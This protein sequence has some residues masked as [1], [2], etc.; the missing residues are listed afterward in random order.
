MALNAE[1][2]E[3]TRP[4]GSAAAAGRVQSIRAARETQRLA[5][6]AEK[7]AGV[8]HWRFDVLSGAVAGSEAVRRSF[9]LDPAEAVPSPRRLLALLAPEDRA[10][11][12]RSLM[13]AIRDATPFTL[14][15]RIVTPGGQVRQVACNGVA[16]RDGTGA[17]AALYG[18]FQDLTETRA[19]ERASEDRFRLLAE[20]TTDVIY[21]VDPRGVITYVTPACET[22][23][24][25]APE[26]MIGTKV[27]SYS[28]PDDVAPIRAVIADL[29]A[30]GPG[31]API[32]TLYRVRRKD[33]GHLWVEGR[34]KINFD[35]A[36]VQVS[37]QDV[38]RDVTAQKEA[39]AAIRRSEERFRMLAENASDILCVM[40]MT[41]AVT[42]VT[43]ACEKLLGYT[44]AEMIGVKVQNLMHPD[45]ARRILAQTAA[46]VAAGPGAEW[47][48]IEYRSWH[49]EGRWVWIEGKPK[50]IFDAK[51]RPT[52][53]QDV[54]RDIGVRKAAELE[55][56]RA[57]DAAEAATAA[58]SDFLANMS[59]EIR[60]PLTAIIGF[61][62]LLDK[63]EEL[64]EDSR[65]SVRRIV[66][67]GQ[68]LLTLV[69]DI[70]DFSKLE[71][72]Q[73]ALDPQPFEPAEF[74]RGVVDLVAAQAQ[75]KGLTVDLRLDPDLP[76]LVEADNA[77]LRQILLNLLTNALKFTETGGVTV[78]AGYR[79]A[80]GLL[81]ISVTD[82]GSG[83]PEAKRGRLFER[84]SQV[85]SSVS[86]RQGGVGLGLAIC[87]SLVE[88]MGGRIHVESAEGVGSTFNFTVAAPL[89]AVA[90]PRA[91]LAKVDPE[92]A[93]GRPGQVLVVDDVA[94]N[95]ELIR[96]LLE[97]IGQ[98]VEEASSGAEA[99]S[100]AIGRTYDLILM[101]IQMPGM[102]GMTATRAIR[103]TAPLN[104]ATPIVA[105]S[106]NVLADQVARCLA[107]GMDDH[108]AKPIQVADFVAKVSHWIGAERLVA[109]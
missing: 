18:A 23:L 17:V 7:L 65:R 52:A 32:V 51:G 85:D 80:D 21:Q 11:V 43:Q 74:V 82:T 86:R 104:A 57:R 62:A 93:A 46:Y 27:L 41:G 70:L 29:I 66:T 40:D 50:I 97:A 9:G 99:I 68:A 94:E 108:I 12:R 20:H 95:R 37:L 63:A 31:A 72:N 53:I 89:V 35:A 102:D 90:A 84:F 19:R 92:P 44:P 16:E 5:R 96:L 76:A 36:G 83:I 8:G 105:I 101:D 64:S 49:K 79:H 60:T 34:P 10:R 100:A 98:S 77:R 26:E 30:A 91:P 71:A 22:L 107:A 14:E 67:G 56:A 106:A 15:G 42:F 39:D 28:H 3:P 33:G 61:S 73:V 4:S 25:Y 6:M 87:K 13:R 38:I 24:G 81:S 47:I 78:S 54:V 75:A 69:N 1:S 103:E 88:M 48:T 45:D 55:L 2:I 109:A 59:H 58:K